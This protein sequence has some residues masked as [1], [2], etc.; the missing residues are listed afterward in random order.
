MNGD[1]WDASFKS[2]PWML[3]ISSGTNLSCSQQW[4]WSLW[5]DS[6]V[7]THLTQCFIFKHLLDCFAVPMVLG[8]DVKQLLPQIELSGGSRWSNGEQPYEDI[9]NR[10]FQQWAFFFLVFVQQQVTTRWSKVTT[11]FS[12]EDKQS[13]EN[14]LAELLFFSSFSVSSRSLHQT[15][16]YNTSDNS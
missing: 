7:K 10:S 9:W 13:H 14:K 5:S 2:E 12:S 4:A 16:L 8:S 15:H 6:G 3:K 11:T 1:K